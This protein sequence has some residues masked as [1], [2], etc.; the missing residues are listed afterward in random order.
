LP[1]TSRLE[2][3]ERS[4]ASFYGRDEWRLGP[5]PAILACIEAYTSIVIEM[6]DATIAGLRS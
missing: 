5:R 3:L 2:D 1:T 4:E 6:D